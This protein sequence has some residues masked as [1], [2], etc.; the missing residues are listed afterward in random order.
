MPN[1]SYS[2]LVTNTPGLTDKG[3]IDIYNRPQVKLQDGSTATVRT[4]G[5]TDYRDGKNV[6]IPTIGPNGEDWSPKQAEDY[7]Y[8]TGQHLGKFDTIENADSAAEMLHLQQERYYLRR[9][10]NE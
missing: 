8:K 6:N 5:I 3:N 9:D 10:K 4:M 7:Y 1:D 2:F